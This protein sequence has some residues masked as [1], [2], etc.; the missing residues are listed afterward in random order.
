MNHQKTWHGVV[1][2]HFILQW[3]CYCD[4][5]LWAVMVVVQSTIWWH[6]WA[7]TSIPLPNALNPVGH[8]VNEDIN[9]HYTLPG[10][11]SH[12]QWMFQLTSTEEAI[13]SHWSTPEVSP[14]WHWVVARPSSSCGVVLLSL[15]QGVGLTGVGLVHLSHT[16]QT[17]THKGIP[18]SDAMGRSQ[19]QCRMHE[20]SGWSVTSY[21]GTSVMIWCT[22]SWGW[23]HLSWSNAPPLEACPPIYP[24]SSSTLERHLPWLGQDH[25]ALNLWHLFSGHSTIFFFKP[26]L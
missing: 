10:I 13:A 21:E 8:S 2:T 24:W 11:F 25:Q 1:H 9:T 14:A 3:S 26:L 18:V 20:C 22:T 15:P 19:L 5:V 4:P 16:W 6:L 23:G 7:E 12:P 17:P